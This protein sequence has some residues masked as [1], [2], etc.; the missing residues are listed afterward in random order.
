MPDANNPQLTDLGVWNVFANPDFPKPQARLRQILCDEEIGALVPPFLV[1]FLARCGPARLLLKSVAVFKTP[2][3]EDLSHSAPYM[4]N[5]QLSS[6][7]GVIDLYRQTSTLAH[8]QTLRNGAKQLE[9]IA[10][11]AED[12]APLVAFLRSLNEDY[13]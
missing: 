3:L 11:R 1:P 2:G 9:G 13:Q 12:V 8:P 7:E 6:L 10:L 4:H 5:G